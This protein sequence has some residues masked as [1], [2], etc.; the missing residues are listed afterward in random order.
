MLKNRPGEVG[1]DL[2]HVGGDVHPSLPGLVGDQL[3]VGAG[4]RAGDLDP[5]GQRQLLPAGV[6]RIL[7]H[8]H[9]PHLG[10]AEGGDV[11]DHLEGP[12]QVGPDVTVALGGVER[13]GPGPGL[14]TGHLV[15]GDLGAGCVAGRGA[16][17]QIADGCVAG[18][19]AGGLVV[20]HGVH[21]C[22]SFVVSVA[23]VRWCRFYRM[24]AVASRRRSAAAN[25]DPSAASPTAVMLPNN[26]TSSGPV[27]TASWP[28]SRNCWA[29]SGPRAGSRCKRRS[30][31]GRRGAPRQPAG[32]VD[33]GL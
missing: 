17:G 33:G 22:R 15:V 13:D 6:D 29:A 10:V 1:V 18:R 11:V 32:G 2:H 5:L 23:A 21:S 28:R 9:Q 14:Q 30:A 27:S 16:G 7:G 24:A 26:S 8:H 12:G 31:P 25:G 3:G 19:G 4:D 20:G